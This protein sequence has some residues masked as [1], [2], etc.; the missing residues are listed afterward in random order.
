[1]DE[2]E[3]AVDMLETGAADDAQAD[4]EVGL[5]DLMSNLTEASETNETAETDEGDSTPETQEHKPE[6]D[7]DKFSRRIASAL[8]NQK[9]GFQKELDFSARVRSVSGDLTD[10]EIAEALRSYRASKIAGSDEE[11]S[12]KAARR[13]V[14]EQEKAE[15]TS[16]V[17]DRRAALTKEFSSLIEDGWT[18]DELQAFSTDAQVVQD[19]NSGMSIRKAAKA[20]LQ[21]AQAPQTRRRSV[22]TART[23]G[24]GTVPDENA[25]ESMTDE[26]FARFSERAQTLM[27]EGKK[28]KF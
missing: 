8:A 3:N 2:L 19:V 11:I 18:K 28:V 21:R 25:I 4:N 16:A 13:I 27:M 7:K 23:A 9:K 14:E 10:E 20:Y 1:M 15:G 12:P 24:A 17:E 22:P 5:D 26:E 6:G